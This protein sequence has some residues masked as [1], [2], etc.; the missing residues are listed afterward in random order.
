VPALGRTIALIA[1]IHRVLGLLI[2]AG[3]FAAE[4]GRDISLVADVTQRYG[5]V[6]ACVALALLVPL[7]AERDAAAVAWVSTV[8]ALGAAGLTAW[9]LVKHGVNPDYIPRSVSA[10]LHVCVF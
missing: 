7:M 6:C 1:K 3:F 9:A 2:L 10:P 5:C 4:A 8:A